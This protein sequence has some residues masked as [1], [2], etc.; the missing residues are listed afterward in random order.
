MLGSVEKPRGEGIKAQNGVL[1][2]SLSQ[3]CH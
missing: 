2:G 3:G 1:K